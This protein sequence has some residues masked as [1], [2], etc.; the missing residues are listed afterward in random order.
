MECT[1]C[2][3]TGWVDCGGQYGCT[4]G[5]CDCDAGAALQADDSRVGLWPGVVSLDVI[6]AADLKAA[7]GE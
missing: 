6:I 4:G 2:E 1:R 3:D 5:Y 7:F